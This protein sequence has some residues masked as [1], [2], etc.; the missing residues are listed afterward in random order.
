MRH[1]RQ[2]IHLLHRNSINLIIKITTRL[3]NPIPN[4]DIHQ[5]IHRNILPRQ[6]IR[7][8]NPILPHDRCRQLGRIGSQLSQRHGRREPHPPS[9]LLRKSHIRRPLVQTYPHR[10]QFNLQY[11]PMAIQSFLPR[12]QYDE[13]GIGIT[14]AG[15]D[16]LSSSLAV[17]GAFDDT[18]EVEYLDLGP[19]VV[20]GARDAGEGGEFV[21]GRF[22]FGAGEFALEGGF[23]YGGEADEG[24]AGVS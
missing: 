16:F 12:I 3:I 19:F 15:D 9:R 14:G 1:P 11:L 4:N 8:H 7:A 17:G 22:G 20:H 5:L 21:G 24:Y 18:G 10:L 2:L 23:S 13:D 6:Q